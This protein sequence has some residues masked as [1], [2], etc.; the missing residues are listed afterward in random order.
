MGLRAFGRSGGPAVWLLL[1][2][3]LVSLAAVGLGAWVC[4]ASG[5][6]TG[7]WSRNLIA[8]GVG[9]GLA[10]G[11]AFAGGR[12]LSL[13]IAL[14]IALAAAP[15]G[16]AAS[17]LFADQEG[18]HRWIDLGPVHANVA[19]LLLPAAVVALGGL[20]GGARLWPWFLTVAAMVLL[21]LQPD[22]SQALAL[23]AAAGL[24]AALS[25]RRVA[26][27]FAVIA[28]LAGFA[29]AAWFRPDPLDS[30]P[31]VEGLVGLAFKVSPF[32]GAGVLIL[33]AAVIVAPVLA[34]RTTDTAVRI[35]SW[36]LGA[37]LLLWAVAPWLGAF[38]VPFAGVGMSPI[39]GAWLGVGLLAGFAR[40]H[41][42]GRFG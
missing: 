7:S 2:F 5:V 34:L 3:A 23:A 33:I 41:R 6:P 30:V 42:P 35:A 14:A 27:R 17:F 24:I 21:V 16:L 19:M 13:A 25:V 1:V 40:T 8:W 38:P 32:A 10:A 37:C 36:G 11:L 29:A 31:E 22:A 28:A 18:V 39:V 12:P 4:A 20:A 15:S 9:A 26:V